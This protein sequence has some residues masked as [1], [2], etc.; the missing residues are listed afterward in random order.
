MKRYKSYRG[1]TLLEV[2]VALAVASML[3]LA[4][5]SLLNQQLTA[6]AV[7]EKKAA[8][9]QLGWNLIELYRLADADETSQ[10]AEGRDVMGDYA[11]SWSRRI[12]PAGETGLVLLELRVAVE[13]EILYEQ[14]LFLEPE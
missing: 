13:D 3:F 8:A 5:G 14:R 11:F 1:F 12:S 6:G 9:A 4:V 2:M 10:Y 7:L